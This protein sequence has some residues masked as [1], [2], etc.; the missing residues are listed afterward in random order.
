MQDKGNAQ[1]PRGKSGG[2]RR[3]SAE[4]DDGFGLDFAQDEQTLQNS[5]R[6]QY[7]RFD[8]ADFA[9]IRI[10]PRKHAVF[11]ALRKLSRKRIAASVRDKANGVAAVGQLRRQSLRGE[12][13]SVNY[14]TQ[15]FTA[16]NLTTEYPP[17]RVVGAK[18][19]SS[20]DGKQVLR[21]AEVT[22][23][24]KPNPHYTVSVG[25][26]SV[27]PQK[28]VFGTNAVLKLDGFPVMYLPVFWRSLDS[29]KP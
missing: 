28:R 8:F 12:N 23:C 19:I 16:D 22:C 1:N 15:D 6:H 5:E 26:L 17:L 21:G 2:K 9:Q 10:S 27:S 4:A 20:K 11:F 29:Q 24:N 14:T 25:K 3:V 7:Q 18:Q 13:V